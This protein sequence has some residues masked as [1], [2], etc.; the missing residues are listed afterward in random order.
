VRHDSNNNTIIHNAFKIVES[1]TRSEEQMNSYKQ[2]EVIE[3]LA[4]ITVL[5]WL[6]SEPASQCIT[7]VEMFA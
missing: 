1:V 3:L 2:N 6:D 4:S 7:A 5:Q